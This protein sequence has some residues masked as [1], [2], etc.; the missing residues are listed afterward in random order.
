MP[1]G[2]DAS[3][4]GKVCL[5]TGATAGI[6]LVTAEGLARRGAEVVLVGRN[7]EK[8]EATT[9]R[10]RRDAGNPAVQP[11]VADLSSQAEVRRLAGEVL[12]RHP[13]LDVLVNNAGALFAGRKESV[14][15]I[16]LTFALNHLAYFLLTNLLLDALKAG[17]PARVVNVS[18][19]AH[20][21]TRID[22]ES[23]R[24]RRG[25]AGGFGAYGQSK[26]ANLLFTFELARRLEGT[27]VT[28]NALHPGFV[29][30]DFTA[31][32]GA[33]GWVFRRMASV[34]AI[35][36]VAGAR[37]TLYLATAPE[38]AMVTGRYFVKEKEAR[39]SAASR[40]EASARRLW[41]ISEE[42]T[43]LPAAARA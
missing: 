3:M 20:Q 11:L 29:A 9:D 16:E 12:A 15:G 30:T 35:D 7:R 10:I 32:N 21:G 14:D 5:V 28:A 42:M 4:A 25:F 1:A 40:D 43:G 33:L 39:S 31:G 26:L 22:F 34:F 23:L 2:N 24:A 36:P 17:A 27:G 37:T 41:E 6:G 13:R 8:T 19:A 18:S 38:V